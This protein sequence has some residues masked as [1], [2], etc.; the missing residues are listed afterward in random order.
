LTV[1][2]FNPIFCPVPLPFT[3]IASCVV[4]TPNTIPC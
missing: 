4:A 2:T 1:S 3:M